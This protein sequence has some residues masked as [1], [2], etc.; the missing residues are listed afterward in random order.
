VEDWLLCQRDI[1]TRTVIFRAITQCV[2]VN[3]YRRFG[4]HASKK[5]QEIT[6]KA[7]RNTAKRHLVLQTE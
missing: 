5:F 4:T 3:P 2:V 1:K 7:S 6:S